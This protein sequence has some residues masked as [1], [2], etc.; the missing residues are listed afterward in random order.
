MNN[1]ENISEELLARYLAKTATESEIILIQNW[2]ALSPSNAREFA[3]YKTIWEYSASLQQKNSHVDTDAAWN[4]VKL[5]MEKSVIIPMEKTDLSQS[6]V[7]N[8]KANQR[9][10]P[11]TTWA[12]AVIALLV[13]AYG[14]Y[15]F[16]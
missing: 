16:Q 15:L 6:K 5:K 14:W 11:V 1:H 13:M 7:L 10:F 12:A 9:K 4:K 2:L 3:D 8:S